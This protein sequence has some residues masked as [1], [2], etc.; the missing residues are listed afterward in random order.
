MTYVR[1]FTSDPG[2]DVLLEIESVN[3]L[4][5]EPPASIAGIGAGVACL[6]GEFENGDFN[7]PTEVTSA[8]DMVNT[9][10]S[11]GYT[12]SGTQ[13]QYPCAVSRQADGA[14]VPEYW[15]G[16]GFVQLNGKKFKR[17][18]LVR[19]DTNVGTVVFTRRAAVSGTAKPTYA[20]DSAQTLLVKVNGA[21]ASTVTWDSAAGTVK[22]TA[23]TFAFVGGELLTLGYDSAAD[24]TVMFLAGDTTVAAVVSRINLAAGFA[25]ATVDT[26]QVRL[27]SRRKGTGAQVRVVSGTTGVLA[28]LMGMSAATTAGTGDVV[29]S[30]YVTPA[31]VKARIEADAAGTLVEFLADGTPRLCSTTVGTGTIE[32]TGGTAT[33]LGFPVDGSHVATTGVA[34]TIPAGTVVRNAGAT[35]KLVTMQDVTVTAA[36]AGPY[37]V[38]VRHAV[39]T[40]AG[41]TAAPA[42]ITV[43]DSVVEFNS[44]GVNNLVTI[45]AAL[46]EAAIDAAYATAIDSTKDVN[47]VGKLIGLIWSARQS[48]AIRRA[49]RTNALTASAEGCYGRVAFVR[50]PMNTLKAIAKSTASEPGVGPYRSDRVV[51]NYPNAST[52]VPLIARVGTTGGTGFT[53]DGIVDVGAD[54]FCVSVCSQLNPEENPGQANS[55]LGGIVGLES[56]TN[57]TGFGMTDYITFKAA[58]ICALNLS[59]GQ[60]EFQSGVTSVDPLVYPNLKNIARRRMADYIQDTLASR[61]KA[62]S[63][64]LS[65]LKRRKAVEGEIRAWLNGLL[66]KTDESTQRID[67][68]SVSTKRNTPDQLARGLFRIIVNVRTLSSL[69]SIVLQTT[70]GE[71]VITVEEL[72][73]A[74]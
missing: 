30:L 46:S 72:P 10:G 29:D 35:V 63:K 39:D 68:F 18:I 61:V 51:Y 19:V 67:W 40:G 47:S 32:V 17:L 34:G 23:G 55:F 37:S 8:E 58:G 62:F 15:N 57:V 49:L 66:G 2:D 13:G 54:G 21:G 64:K 71:S 45:S 5:L 9:L 16:N 70:I 43:V 56:G 59:G 6:V 50:P 4:D 20:I 27:T 60:A 42:T 69:D 31:E 52:L 1:R 48:N 7:A 3:I 41:L 28:T 26:G 12:Y 14:V 33:D 65:T 24:F 73:L 74:A 36:L 38:K 44:F 53:A 22:G 11:L 25:F